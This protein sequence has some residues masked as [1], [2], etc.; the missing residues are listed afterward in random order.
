M[1][2][3]GVVLRKELFAFGL[4][5]IEEERRVERRAVFP[6]PSLQVSVEG[7][8]FG[9][10]EESN[11]LCL[12]IAI[13]QRKHTAEDALACHAGHDD[14]ARV[15]S[16]QLDQFPL[17]PIGRDFRIG[18]ACL[19]HLRHDEGG[20]RLDLSGTG[21]EHSCPIGISLHKELRNLRIEVL[22]RRID[23]EEVGRSLSGYF[24][25]AERY[26]IVDTSSICI[27]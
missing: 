5:R 11:Q 8:P 23:L 9:I 10:A 20:T 12:A 14:D 25:G 2:V 16:E 6:H 21:D 22:L 27:A 24:A 18:S 13:G 4:C 26:H 15:G 3:P 1:V 7:L 19:V 17:L